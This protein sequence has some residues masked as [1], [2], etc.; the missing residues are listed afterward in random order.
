MTRLLLKLTRTIGVC[1]VCLGVFAP[2]NVFYHEVRFSIKQQTDADAKLISELESFR[3]ALKH[4]RITLV[5]PLDVQKIE[6]MRQFFLTQFALAPVLVTR[7]PNSIKLI[8]REVSPM[9]AFQTTLMRSKHY[10]LVEE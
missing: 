4:E 7:T 3:P 5:G 10:V 1:L 9:P 6:R 2:L 8:D